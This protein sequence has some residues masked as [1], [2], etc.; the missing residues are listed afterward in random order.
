MNTATFIKIASDIQEKA[1]THGITEYV[2]NIIEPHAAAAA[3]YYDVPVSELVNTAYKV[4]SDI[5][6]YG[7]VVLPE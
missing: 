6:N 2:E 4:A 3:A 5:E 1:G 7:F